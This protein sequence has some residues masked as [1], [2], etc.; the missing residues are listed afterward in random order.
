VRKSTTS[1]P[2]LLS[3]RTNQPTNQPTNQSKSIN[4]SVSNYNGLNNHDML[5]LWLYA[6]FVCDA[7]RCC[8]CSAWLVVPYKCWAFTCFTFATRSSELLITEN[9]WNRKVSVGA[10]MSQWM[11][12]IL[13]ISVGNQRGSATDLDDSL[14]E[15]STLLQL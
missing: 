6:R 10:G 9:R 15:D 1:S 11:M 4:Q 7:K 12:C 13:D 2:V 8:S 5:Q 14:K 3:P